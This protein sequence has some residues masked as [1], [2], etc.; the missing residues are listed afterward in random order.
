MPPDMHKSAGV[1]GMQE[2]TGIKYLA[3]NCK[4]LMQLHIFTLYQQ[5]TFM[6]QN[7]AFLLPKI[8]FQH[9]S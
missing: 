3:K 2:E 4:S 7:S 1:C 6:I 5:F 8:N 9:I